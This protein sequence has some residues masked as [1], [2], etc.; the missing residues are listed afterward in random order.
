VTRISMHKVS[1]VLGGIMVGALLVP[2]GPALAAANQVVQ[3]FITNDSAHPVPVTGS[4]RVGNT[5]TTTPAIP[6]GYF[7][8][9]LGETPS[10]TILQDSGRYAIS[11]LLIQNNSSRGGGVVIYTMPVIASGCDVTEPVKI[12]TFGLVAGE[13]RQLTFPV[14]LLSQPSATPRCLYVVNDTDVSALIVGYRL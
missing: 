3:S 12:F 7:T 13:D 5:V 11:S 2:G 6:D 1:L 14:P 4:V 8:L 10:P 9:Q